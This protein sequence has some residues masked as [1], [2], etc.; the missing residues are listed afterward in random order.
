MF[1]GLVATVGTTYVQV[2]RF[3]GLEILAAV[4]VGLLAVALLVVNNLRDIAGD[5]D[6]GKRTLATRIGA[7][8]T[9][10]CYAVAMLVPFALAVASAFSRPWALLALAALPL[11]VI[12]VRRVRAGEAGR[13]LIEVLGQT[14]RAQLAFG[15]L[16]AVGLAL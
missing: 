2:G 9:R 15:A 6:A 5:T 14:G 1:F 4:P 12:P 7:P 13:G 10:T 16:L 11:A 8:A 3:T